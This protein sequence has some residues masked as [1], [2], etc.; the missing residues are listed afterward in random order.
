MKVKALF[1]A[2]V[3]VHC[4][5][6]TAYS[7]KISEKSS[8]ESILSVCQITDGISA[9]FCSWEVFQTQADDLSIQT[10]CGLLDD[11]GLTFFEQ[12]GF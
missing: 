10:I 3:L 7:W 8:R 11:F 5:L 2:S 12:F 4:T 1:C 9:A 6:S